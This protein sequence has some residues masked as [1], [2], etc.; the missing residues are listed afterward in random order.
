MAVVEATPISVSNLKNSKPRFNRF[1]QSGTFLTKMGLGLSSQAAL[2]LGLNQI[3]EWLFG[4]EQF[5]TVMATVLIVVACIGVL[6][7]MGHMCLTHR[8]SLA[9]AFDLLSK[10]VENKPKLPLPSPNR[11]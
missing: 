9:Q 1:K 5:V 4:D 7:C 3:S 11:I 6:L 10:T 8:S 2:Y